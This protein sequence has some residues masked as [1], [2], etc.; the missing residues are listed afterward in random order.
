MKSFSRIAALCAP[1]GLIAC[2]GGNGSGGGAT[3]TG[4]VAGTTLTVTDQSAFSG[5]GTCNGNT[6]TVVAVNLANVTGQ[7]SAAQASKATKNTTS[8]TLILVLP[9]GGTI[10]PGTYQ[11]VNPP[12]GTPVAVAAFDKTDDSCNPTLTANGST[13]KASLSANG[14]TVTISAIS[15]SAVSGNFAL[16]FGGGGTLAGGFN[17]AICNFSID[18]ICASSGS[19]CG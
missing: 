16:T 13:T 11:I 2:G 17:A 14:G 9:G 7:C 10:G 19:T 4:T 6:A 3:L 15:S 18:K 5:T 8:L 1:L 12:A